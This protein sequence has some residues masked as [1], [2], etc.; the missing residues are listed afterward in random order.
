MIEKLIPFKSNNHSLELLASVV[1]DIKKI[2]LEF[3]LTGDIK[4]I[5]LPGFKTLDRKIGLWES[6]CFEL[7]LLSNDMSYYEFNFSPDGNWNC[8]Y[9]DKKGDPLEESKCDL[10]D[11]KTSTEASTY[12]LSIEIDLCSMKQNFTKNSDF[13]FNLA[14]VLDS[15][16]L[17]YWALDHGQEKPN[18]HDFNLYRK[19]KKVR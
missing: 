3:T 17:S 14:S 5:S 13:K 11:F 8:F 10:I 16:E 18:F 2:S 15:G 1:I 19:I 6:T 9:F 12:K 7:F 4:N